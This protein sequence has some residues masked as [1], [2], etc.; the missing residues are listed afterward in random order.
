ML[1]PFLMFNHKQI[2]NSRKSIK[3]RLIIQCAFIYNDSKPTKNLS[4][5]NI[6]FIRPLIFI[7][8]KVLIYLLRIIVFNRNI[9]LQPK[10]MPTQ[11][12][13]HMVCPKR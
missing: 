10:K 4:N 6:K 2:K 3:Y 9:Y 5:F 7:S 8:M 13:N 1:I 12:E 11:P